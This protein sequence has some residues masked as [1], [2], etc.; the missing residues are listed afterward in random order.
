MSKLPIEKEIRLDWQAEINEL[1]NN[2]VDIPK[3]HEVMG[4][5]KNWKDSLL[6]KEKDEGN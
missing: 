4:L 1:L 5:L 6:W 3:F 2:P